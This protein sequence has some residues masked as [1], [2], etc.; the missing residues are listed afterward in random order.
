[1]KNRTPVFLSIL[2]VISLLI[3]GFVMFKGIL[4]RKPKNLAGS[5]GLNI[6]GEFTKGENAPT[7]PPA[8]NTF[9]QNALQNTKDT[10]SQKAVEIEKTV[11]ATIEKE[12]A[13]MTKSQVEAVKLQICRDW[14]V[15]GT[16]P[17]KTP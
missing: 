10:L 8:V 17:T 15:I 5:L 9:F 1:M 11:V 2:A 6:L 12:V 16:T 7:V 14:G 13:Q 3:I 4:T